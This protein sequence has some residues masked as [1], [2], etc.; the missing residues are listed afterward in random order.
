MS[1]RLSFAPHVVRLGKALAALRAEH[2]ED[3]ESWP[4]VEP[5]PVVLDVAEW[6]QRRLHKLGNVG[7]ELPTAVAGVMRDVVNRPEV[8]EA[9]Q[10][11]VLAELSA[12]LRRLNS[13]YLNTAA[14]TLP[15]GFH[16]A[17]DLLLSCYQDVH[18]QV[19]NWLGM[20]CDA[21]ADPQTALAKLPPGARRT[22]NFQLNLQPPAA[23]QAT[24][25]AFELALISAVLPKD[26]KRSGS[27]FWPFVLGAALGTVWADDE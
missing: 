27:W 11:N 15:H 10:A 1:G 17:Q 12:V 13:Q 19:I 8:S 24:V 20:V 23:L 3:C 18:Q 5:G 4:T 14:A 21:I 2:L 22:L 26:K 25:D 16:D 9:E 6:L 7:R